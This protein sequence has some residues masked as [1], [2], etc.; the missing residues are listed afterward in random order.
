MSVNPENIPSSLKYWRN[1]VWWKEEVRGVELT[2][3]PFDIRTGTHAKSNDPNTW[4]TWDNV[5]DYHE[6]HSGNG[7]RGVGFEL[8]D[9]KSTPY[10]VIDLDHCVNVQTGEIEQQAKS[11]ID[12]I[13]SYSEY[14]PSGTGIH[15]WTIAVLPDGGRK[16]GN[17]EMYDGGRYLTVTGN[18]L[19]GT[20]LAVECRH[21]EI[22]EL[23][24]FVFGEK[25]EQPQTENV[26]HGT[27]DNDK[28]L[29][30]RIFASKNGEAFKKLWE[31]DFCNY[32]SHSEAD[33]ALCYHLAFWTNKNRTQI[34]RL[35]RQSK[36]FREKWDEKHGESTYGQMTIQKAIE[37]TTDVYKPRDERQPPKDGH[38][39]LKKPK[40]TL[41]MEYFEEFP[42]AWFSN[43]EVRDATG[44]SPDDVRNILRK[45]REAG[46]LITDGK[47]HR[48]TPPSRIVDPF[49]VMSDAFELEFP[50]SLHDYAIISKGDVAVVS[51]WK[52]CGKTA[53]L[54]DTALLNS[55][56]GLAVN[57]CVTEN[58]A[59][60]GRRYLQWGYTAEEI[61]ERIT[62]R[63]CR[64][65]DYINIIKCDCLNILDYY[66][67]SN[68]EYARTATDIEAMAKNLG[69][70][71][72][73]IGIQHAE[74]ALMPRGKELSQELSQM[75][76]V[77]SNVE[78][79]RG[80]LEGRKVGKARILTVKEPGVK[81][82]A[83]GKVCRYEVSA[84]GGR[85]R[86]MDA[87]DYP[88][89]T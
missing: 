17:V 70:G 34:D 16:K 8:G 58:V 83:E 20:P 47:K 57:Y 21:E 7:T 84:I 73:I 41:V 86:Q 11:I 75:S 35:F 59:K 61:R 19:E 33:S 32:P 25:K 26:N 66:N 65:R 60:I 52:N 13:N 62:F 36:L 2:K 68:G 4:S 76:V 40:A 64:D 14:S 43:F 24:R 42:S 77:L 78:A 71:V 49:E 10:V 22:E 69:S 67:P 28:E 5:L 31:G 80:E 63:D 48:L 50:L 81:K 51:G 54:M 56:R 85:L 1:W 37:A 18:H 44:L 82:G 88:K 30:T 45:K 29:V 23:H 12:N 38:T 3:P 87:W 27:Q 89:K 74:G 79:I 39:E 15:I 53:F 9:S 55:M 46:L 6:A 72:L